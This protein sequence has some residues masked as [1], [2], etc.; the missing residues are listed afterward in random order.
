MGS[1][2]GLLSPES[3][4]TSLL[5][6]SGRLKSSLRPEPVHTIKYKDRDYESASEAL[7][8]YIADFQQSLRTSEASVGQLELFK[9][10][11]TPRRHHLGYRN[12]D[13]DVS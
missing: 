4:V 8:A 6:S 13:G 2:D 3:S 5:A 10:A 11:A 1:V 7:D 9:E 12:R